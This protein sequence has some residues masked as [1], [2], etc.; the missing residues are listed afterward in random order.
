MDHPTSPPLG[1]PLMKQ[2]TAE[3][4]LEA[5]HALGASD[6]L[7]PLAEV[8]RWLGV[9]A[10][11]MAVMIGQISGEGLARCPTPTRVRL[12]PRGRQATA[13]VVRRRRLLEAL[14]VRQ[15][16][17]PVEAAQVIA[18]RLAYAVPGDII[19]EAARAFGEPDLTPRAEPAPAWA[20]AMRRR[21]VRTVRAPAQTC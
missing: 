12:T 14:L 10:D 16:G 19:D 17:Y 7:V 2:S 6:R 15:H 13:R 5:L 11:L 4:C 9:Q 8:A 21:L 3:D 1:F 20:V 18:A